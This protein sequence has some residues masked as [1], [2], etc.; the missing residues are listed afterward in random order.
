MSDERPGSEDIPDDVTVR[1]SPRRGLAAAT[2]GFFIGFAG[3]VYGPAAEQFETPMGLSGIL[4]GMLVDAPNPIGSLICIPFDAWT[5]EVGTR[6][7]SNPPGT[8]GRRNGR[9]R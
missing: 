3:V 8:L 7:I 6:T 9:S 5:D 1:G 2:F 4:R